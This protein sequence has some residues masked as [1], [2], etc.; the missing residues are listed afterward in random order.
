MWI[1][2]AHCHAE[3]S[4]KALKDHKVRRSP[5]SLGHLRPVVRPSVWSWCCRAPIL[6]HSTIVTEAAA[7]RFASGPFNRMHLDNL[8]LATPANRRTETR[9]F[10]FKSTAT[11]WRPKRYCSWTASTS[12]TKRWLLSA[13]NALITLNTASLK[14]PM[15]MMSARSHA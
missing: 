15:F 2:C 7:T 5:I 14:P 9:V 1:L 12:A 10:G 8:E 4:E 11:G 13:R 3:H 6:K